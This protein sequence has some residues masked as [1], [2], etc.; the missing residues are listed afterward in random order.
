MNN[1]I[2]TNYEKQ[3]ASDI[4]KPDITIKVKVHVNNNYMK[5]RKKEQTNLV[6][7]HFKMCPTGTFEV[8]F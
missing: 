8:A 2:T 5:K 3:F 6:S 7:V 1:N 4:K